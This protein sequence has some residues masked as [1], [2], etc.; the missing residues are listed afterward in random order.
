MSFHLPLLQKCCLDGQSPKLVREH[1]NA[2]Q[3]CPQRPRCELLE[4]LKSP[5]LQS[6][7]CLSPTRVMSVKRLSPPLVLLL[8]QAELVEMA[9]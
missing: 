5:V 6:E 4:L 7:I 3:A 1:L 2:Y 9:I 8:P